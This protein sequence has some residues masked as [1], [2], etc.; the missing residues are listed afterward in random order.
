MPTTAHIPPQEETPT[1]ESAP[2][3]AESQSEATLRAALRRRID[4]APLGQLKTVAAY[5]EVTS[6]PQR[7]TKSV[8]AEPPVPASLVRPTDE[9]LA[10]ELDERAARDETVSFDEA[11]T[12]VTADR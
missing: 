1:R 2:T 9:A 5:F 6:A 7:L 8:A 3:P 11:W 12:S 4:E 10:R